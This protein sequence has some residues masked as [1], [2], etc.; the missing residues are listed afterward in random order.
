MNYLEELKKWFEE[1]FLIHNDKKSEK[2][3]FK[4]WEIYYVN[5]WVNI[6]S[7]FNYTRPAIIFEKSKLSF[8]RK[9]VIVIPITS[10]KKDK[11]YNWFDYFLKKSE[12]NNLKENSIVKI[13]HVRDVSKSR[14]KT[15]IWQLSSQELSEII[16]IFQKIY[17]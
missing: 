10:F 16:E 2:N 5:F 4:Q 8:W 15:K 3:L 13:L 17:K 12:L 11:K 7:E 9:N 6:W 14:V 1:K